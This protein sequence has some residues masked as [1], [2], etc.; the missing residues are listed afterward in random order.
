M[1][2]LR[3]ILSRLPLAVRVPL[4][5]AAVTVLVAAAISQVVLHRLAQEQ[6]IALE[7]L[8]SAFMDGLS[9]TVTPGLLTRDSWETF[10]VLDRAKQR[11]EAVHAVFMVVLLPNGEVLA[12]SEPDRFP[13]RSRLPDAL[14]ARVAAGDGLVTDEATGRAWLV[15]GI[16]QEGFAIGTVLT[17]IDISNLLRV[18]REVL[19]TLIVVN[20]ALTLLFGTA[21]YLLVRRL[22]APL[23]LIRERLAA[24][25]VGTPK[26][27]D[28]R[29]I[30]LAGREYAG[31]FRQFNAMIQA[32]SERES[33]AAE[34]ANQEQLA[35]LGRLASSMAH[36]VNNPLGGLM[37]AVDTLAAHGE[38]EAV[39]H[40]VID[41]VR[42][43]LRGIQQVV[44]AALATYKSDQDHRRLSQ[45]DLQD[46][47]FLIQHETGAKRLALDWQNGLPE[48]LEIDAS[49]IRQIVLNLLLNACHASPEGGTVS[50]HA[51]AA[52]GALVIAVADQG[53]GL[54]PAALQAI[55]AGAAGRMVPE[56]DGLRRGLGLWT[57]ARLA[58]RLGGALTAHSAADGGQEEGG[59][60]V[61]LT[62]PFVHTADGVDLGGLHAVA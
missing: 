29:T 23:S 43:G 22:V 44:R 41:L 8:T 20:G 13:I 18:R 11:Y 51:A 19:W 39:R 47:R 36:E 50:L 52:P 62:V 24:A 60:V 28:D 2:R 38:D 5:A 48:K 55:E 56:R 58:A 37:N 42:R 32:Q 16:V 3:S 33:L 7:S 15:R 34:L 30:D 46:L 57:A 54:P 35:M 1:R 4:L 31:L 6:A 14:A 25:A 26:P 45:V 40:R 17:E 53:P 10:D 21:G 12:A 59:A 61:T 9:T 27:F 49:P